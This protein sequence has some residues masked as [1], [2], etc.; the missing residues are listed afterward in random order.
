M[1]LKTKN[2]TLQWIKSISK[3]VIPGICAISLVGMLNALCGVILALQSKNVIDYAVKRNSDELVNSAILLGVLIILQ[4]LLSFLYM[5]ISA[6]IVAKHTLKLQR[7]IFS[8]AV[9]MQYEQASKK[10]SGELL[11]RITVDSDVVMCAVI[12]II[13]QILA[14]VTGVVSAFVALLIIQPL[15]AAVCAGVGV[16]VGVG[17]ML[18]GKRLKK[19]TLV[20]RKW[21]DK[22]N[23]FMLECIQNLLVIKSFANEKSVV[24]HA[25]GIQDNT[26]KALK[27]R[28]INNI[29][30]SLAAEFAFTFGY[31]LALGWGAFGIAFGTIS[32]GNLMAMIQLVGK[33]QSPF[34]GIASVIPQYYQMLASAERLMD[35]VQYAETK[36]DVD[37][38]DFESIEFK[39]VSFS[40]NKEETILKE[41]NLKIEKGD[42]VLI[43]GI[44]GIGKST[45]L[46]LLL[47]MYKPDGGEILLKDN[48]SSA[49]NLD[50]GYR[51]LFSYVPQGNMVL[52][53]TVEEN[54]VFFADDI[55]SKKVEECLKIACL[56]D[57]ITE[58]PDGV[59]T[60]V[61]EHGVGLSEGQV[62]RLAVAR[63]IYRDVPVLLLDEA[64]SA[65][66]EKTEAKMLGNI[67]SLKDKTC[68]LISH[69]TA[70]EAYMDKKIFI[71]NGKIT[72]N[73]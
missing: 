12:G 42:F 38:D 8:D 11:N 37:I 53:G 64:T 19:Y 66:D 58:M 23:S 60:I 65:L 54:V 31:F 22:G 68:I 10:H 32:Y 70:A 55:D 40:Y 48:N 34:K 17:A 4:F 24:K 35:I 46:K 67:K 61:G 69:K 28:N 33:V 43:S 21:S 41:A 5:K 36:K 18:W 72:I 63:A 16:V 25:E 29:F 39:N 62:Q 51:K 50:A 2:P 71:K 56:W 52:S 30:A 15:F 26:Y 6:D 45:L 49:H 44:S 20:C 73:N 57:D 14:F 9:N 1:I 47:C 7:R 3:P 59:N 27:K 13:P